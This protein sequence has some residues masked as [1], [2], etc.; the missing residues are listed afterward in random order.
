MNKKNK[1]TYGVEIKKKYNVDGHLYLPEITPL[2]IKNRCLSLL[3]ENLSSSDKN[4]LV[5][6]LNIKDDSKLQELLTEI[7]IGKFKPIGTFLTSKKENSQLRYEEAYDFSAFIVNFNPR[8]YS[9]YLKYN[10]R[11]TDEIKTTTF[12]KKKQPLEIK[13]SGLSKLLNHLYIGLLLVVLLASVWFLRDLFFNKITEPIPRT[14][15]YNTYNGNLNYYYTKKENGDIVLYENT[16]QLPNNKF[17]PVTQEVILTYFKQQNINV[18]NEDT[19]R[20]F[21]EKIVNEN[22]TTIVNT[23]ETATTKRDVKKLNSTITNNT[24]VIIKNSD[25]IDNAMSIYFKNMY[26]KTTQKYLATGNVSYRFRKSSFIK[27]ATVCELVLTYKVKLNNSD[28]L[29]DLSTITSTATGFS[30]VDAKNNAIN[31]LQ[32]K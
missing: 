20:W 27:D 19:K 11:E 29:F 32:F 12:Q 17:K 4:I 6:F 3:K 2:N 16:S 9:K 18:S 23:T 14:I 28:T 10:F 13:I 31:K 30:K 21:K 24:E 26:K 1:S 22:P 5:S 25:D 7:D 8:P 15:I